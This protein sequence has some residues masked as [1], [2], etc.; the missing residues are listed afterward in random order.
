MDL[1]KEVA[2][3][4]NPDIETEKK[5]ERNK[6][7]AKELL[8][9]LDTLEALLDKNIEKR[10]S[11]PRYKEVI[12]QGKLFSNMCIDKMNFC[13]NEQIIKILKRLAV[14]NKKYINQ[15]E[16]ILKGD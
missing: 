11:K 8:R 5:R 15:L 12:T 3:A 14:E 10:E 13:E 2:R 4:I 7:E 1:M 6:E 16:N 9:Q